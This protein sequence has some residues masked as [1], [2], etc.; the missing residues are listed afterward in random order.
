[1]PPCYCGGI[2]K[3][4]WKC[5]LHLYILEEF[6]LQLE[7][8]PNSKGIKKKENEVFD[9]NSRQEVRPKFFILCYAEWMTVIIQWHQK[10]EEAHIPVVY[11]HKM[12]GVSKVGLFWLFSTTS[13]LDAAIFQ[14][15]DLKVRKVNHI[16]QWILSIYDN[17]ISSQSSIYYLFLELPQPGC[18]CRLRQWHNECGGQTNTPNH[19]NL[20][21]VLQSCGQR[22]L[23][24]S[25]SAPASPS[26]PQPASWTHPK[27]IHTHKHTQLHQCFHCEMG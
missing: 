10:K 8:P 19:A 2:A 22:S 27:G 23:L 9:V 6:G 21:W 24:R 11:R 1:M 12:G 4:V 17:M 25:L 3:N 26:N 13:S 14:I 18:S 15:L 16:P 20:L 5:I 7:E